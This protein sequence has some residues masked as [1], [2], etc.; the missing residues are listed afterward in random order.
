MSEFAPE[1]KTQ[2]RFPSNALLAAS[3]V[4]VVTVLLGW[5]IQVRVRMDSHANLI[6]EQERAVNDQKYAL[7]SEINE[8]AGTASM[9]AYIAASQMTRT[10]DGRLLPNQALSAAFVNFAKSRPIIDQ[11]RMIGL[12]GREVITI[13]RI[14]AKSGSS[15]Y[16]DTTSKKRQSIMY[17]SWAEELLALPSG[18]AFVTGL[19]LKTDEA[20]RAEEPHVPIVR[21]GAA[22]QTES[23]AYPFG[24]VIVDYSAENLF[25]RLVRMEGYLKTKIQ[26]SNAQGYWLRGPDPSL[27]WGFVLPDKSQNTMAVSHPD[28]WKEISLTT[29]GTLDHAG[30]LVVFDTMDL[31]VGYQPP[32]VSGLQTAWKIMTWLT[33]EA[34]AARENAAASQVWWWVALALGLFLPAT[35][36]MV[37]DRDQKREASR[38]R[39][40]TRALLQSIAD[41][42]ADGILAGEAVRDAMGDIKDFRLVF[43]NPAAGY[44]LKTFD[45]EEVVPLE[46]RGKFP[47]F[48]APDFFA[49]C[50]QVVVSG[51]RFETEQCAECGSLGRRWFRILVVKLADGVVLTFSDVTRQKLAVHEL[52]QAKETAEVANRAKTQF[53]TM[54]GHEIRTPMNGL[55]G[56]AELL[57]KTELTEEQMDYVSTLRLSGEALL[58]ILDDILDYSHLEYDALHVQS[59]PLEVRELVTQVG[60]LFTMA[61]GNQNL[62]LVTKVAPD[63]PL[64][65]VSDDVRLRQILVNL[66]GNAL[67]F[68][69]EG[70]LLIKV[71]RDTGAHGDFIVFHVVDSGP[72]VSPEMIERLFKPFSQVD[73]TFTRRFGGT[74]LGLSICKRL[75]ETMGGQIGVNTSPGK[76]SDFFFSLPVKTPEFPVRQLV[77]VRKKHPLQNRVF[78]IL[79]VDDDSINRKLIRHMIEKIG[80]EVILTSSGAE[81]IKAFQESA[82]DLI[83]MDVQMPGM[84]GLETTRRIRG[85]E[86]Q[87][88]ALHPTLISALTAN[89]GEKNRQLCFEAGMDIFLSKPVH[90]EELERLIE[91]NTV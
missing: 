90:L 27:E 73:S 50:V 20:G 49:Q 32:G 91:K 19:T 58:R 23:G 45:R 65:I 81:A 85:L 34:L 8:A 30:G 88:G 56:F 22:L 80:A 69:E 57:D 42:S 15:Y 11:I 84:D 53:L 38:S 39:E 61:I 44:I 40:E 72:G 35:Y 62:E 37:S 25:Q 21:A 89:T 51:N 63:V 2:K 76:G 83:L 71:V 68:T 7:R 59:A 55:L 46:K 18:K 14:R 17:E 12:D 3:L 48:F 60:Q 54:M 16:Q 13:K 82:F 47:L 1:T 64:Q 77:P 79:V 6:R 43:S 29:N 33:P 26:I 67:K 74:G 86:K 4:A 28:V 41:T 10:P 31:S 24:Y 78:R 5:L 70:F 52:S 36:L 75:V 66:V 87:T 9:L